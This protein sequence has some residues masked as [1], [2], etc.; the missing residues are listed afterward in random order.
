MSESTEITVVDRSTIAANAARA[1]AKSLP[2]ERQSEIGRTAAMARW[3]VPKALSEGLVSIA[4]RR[5]A[6]AVLSTKLRVLTQE[7]FLKAVGRAGKAKGGKGSRRLMDSEVVDGLP[8]F[9]A[10]E[11]LVPYISDKLR[12]SA[13]PVVFR[14]M[15]NAIAYGYD[16]H[17]LPQVIDV[18]RKARD[19][20]VAALKE[21][22]KRVSSGKR[23]VEFRGVLLPKQEH[24]VRAC[25]DLLGDLATDGIIAMVDRATGFL[26]QEVRDDITEILKQY[27]SPQLL[28][29]T[30]RFPDEFFKQLYRLYGWPYTPGSVKR[31]QCIAHF[32]NKYIYDQLPPGALDRIHELNPM[33]ESGYRK[34]KNHQFL[35]L[36]TGIPH[37]DKQVTSTTTILTL[38][39]A[40]AGT[41][42]F[43]E[44]FYKVH[45]RPL[46][47]PA[48][49]KALPEPETAQGNLFPPELYPARNRVSTSRLTTPTVESTR[50]RRHQHQMLP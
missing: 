10:A 23:N 12:Q 36:H 14:T 21:Y 46:P 13:T 40:G 39:D 41:K 3:G 16:A 2:R 35:T 44:L 24:I 11:N 34:N 27:I 37:L 15:K 8:P 28:P 18:Y 29:W 49:P 6:C 30:E 47:A 4:G 7:T 19:A 1:R 17:L 43:E 48:K 26:E 22:Q 32:I 45:R 31:P 5:I 50:P 38:V 42:P 9:L 25:D 33:Q 20:H